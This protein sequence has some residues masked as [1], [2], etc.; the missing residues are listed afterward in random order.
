MAP[1]DREVNRLLKR[2]VYDD[3]LRWKEQRRTEHLQQQVLD[4]IHQAFS[5]PL[6]Y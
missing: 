3:L 2:K 6:L 1:E 5:F 4:I